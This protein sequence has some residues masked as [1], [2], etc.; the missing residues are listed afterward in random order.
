MNILICKFL[1]GE[2]LEIRDLK[3]RRVFPWA[4]RQPWTLISVNLQNKSIKRLDPPHLCFIWEIFM[5]KCTVLYFCIL[6]CFT[7]ILIRKVKFYLINGVFIS[8]SKSCLVVLIF[9]MYYC[10]IIINGLSVLWNPCHEF[11]HQ[12][13]RGPT[14]KTK[15]S[16]S[17]FLMRV[18]S[19]KRQ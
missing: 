8:S 6:I 13:W 12:R 19:F 18:T 4:K 11:I 15:I 9:I 17:L 2:E 5:Q 1:N 14:F 16:I 10:F 3:A 7:I